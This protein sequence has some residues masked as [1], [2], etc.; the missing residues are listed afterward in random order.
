M[1][2]GLIAA[3]LVAAAPTR[4]AA[5]SIPRRAPPQR[6]PR[7]A[8]HH[9]R[10]VS[11]SLFKKARHDVAPGRR[12][13]AATA[14]SPACGGQARPRPSAAGAVRRARR[15]DAKTARGPRGPRK[16]VAAHAGHGF[17][18]ETL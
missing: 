15:A 9:F 13:A 3:P 6:R 4:R 14:V 11:G 2:S 1:R 17:A 18:V 12:F 8:D 16:W 7:F 10:T 5:R